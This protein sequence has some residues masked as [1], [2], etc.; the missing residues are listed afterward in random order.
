MLSIP[1]YFG[2]SLNLQDELRTPLFADGHVVSIYWENISRSIVER[3][4][5][6]ARKLDV[7]LYCLQAADQRA[8]FKSKKHDDI[9]T[10]SLLTVPNIHNT[11]KLAGI[12]LLHA[13]MIVRLSD[14]L[15]PGLG[16]VKDKL[17]KVLDVVLRESDQ[18]RLNNLPA[19]YCQFVPKYMA[20]G[21]WVQ[22]QK[23]KHS[24][25]SAHIIT[26]AELQNDG[27]ETEEHK[28]DKS[29]ADSVV[30]I[31][32][33]SANFECDI[34]INGAHET[35]EVLRWQFPLVHGMLRTAYAAQ[36][37]TLT[38]GVV[39]DLRRLGGLEDGDWWLAIY[40]MLS[41]AQRLT[42]LILVGY[43]EQVEELLRRGPPTHL[44]SVTETLEERAKITLARFS[45]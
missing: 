21:I 24:P 44:I 1:W 6:D 30:F 16:L 29:M 10:H 17:G 7:P 37:L 27:E 18:E 9:V 43:T 8:T 3:A 38:G 4:H 12:L 39:V 34:N 42:N 45:S 41:R 35:V 5:R 19:G 40:V 31:E 36:G 25:L 11:G 20:K 26:D 15:A 28:A 23:Y 32:L 33:H 2:V 22:L 13:G 14:V